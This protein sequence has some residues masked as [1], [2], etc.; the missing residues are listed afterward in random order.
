MMFVTIAGI[1]LALG[2]FGMPL[3]IVGLFAHSII[4]RWDKNDVAKGLIERSAEARERDR[5]GDQHQAAQGQRVV[6]QLR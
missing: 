5:H 6:A 4:D 3:A 1:V 2:F